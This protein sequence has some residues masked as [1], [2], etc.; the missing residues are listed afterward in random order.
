MDGCFACLHACA[1]GV[2]GIQRPERKGS[3]ELESRMI[4]RCHVSAGNPTLLNQLAL[5]PLLF[6]FSFKSHVPQ[7]ILKLFM[8]CSWFSPDPPAST[9]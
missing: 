7:A 1:L 8:Q 9:L 5:Q 6:F 4:R 2:P 3:L